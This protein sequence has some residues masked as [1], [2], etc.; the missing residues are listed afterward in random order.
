MSGVWLDPGVLSLRDPQRGR[1]ARGTGGALRESGF[2]G[3]P[4]GSAPAWLLLR[5]T[6]HPSTPVGMVFLLSC[7]R[8]LCLPTPRSW[9]FPVTRVL[10]LY[11]PPLDLHSTWNFCWLVRS[12][13]IFF[14]FLMWVSN[15]SSSMCW[16]AFLFLWLSS[17]S[18]V[19]EQVYCITYIFFS[20]LHLVLLTWSK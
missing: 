5:P 15:W 14:F 13:F 4:S 1:W 20:V 12:S 6:C 19:I 17:D 18:F 8:N 2:T 3:Q 9:Y 16:K 10:F 11:F 7:L